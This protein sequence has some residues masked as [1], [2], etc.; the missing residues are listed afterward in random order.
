[1]TLNTAELFELAKIFSDEW[2]RHLPEEDVWVWEDQPPVDQAGQAEGVRAVVEELERRGWAKRAN[3]GPID[4]GSFEHNE[5]FANGGVITASVDGKTF[6][7]LGFIDSVSV[8]AS[9]PYWYSVGSI[10]KT[11]ELADWE[12]ELVNQTTYSD[13]QTE[14]V[15]DSYEGPWHHWADVPDMVGYTAEEAGV[16]WVNLHGKRHFI[17]SVD[18]GL[19]KSLNDEAAMIILAPFTAVDTVITWTP[20]ADVQ[21]I[22]NTPREWESLD[23]VPTDV[24]VKDHT[25]DFLSHDGEKWLT[26]SDLSYGDGWDNFSATAMYGPFTEVLD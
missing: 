18:G 2:D 15:K 22:R 12:K 10:S 16:V 17:R 3:G 21:V 19:T 14:T 4:L 7:E 20:S 1:M 5:K 23:D 11:E 9:S 8:K 25:G 6:R 13:I 26:Y 24:R